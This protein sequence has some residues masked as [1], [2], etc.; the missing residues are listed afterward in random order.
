MKKLLVAAALA[1]L[2][3]CANTRNNAV[4]DAEGANAP[5]TECCG[6]CDK[7]CATEGACTEEAEAMVCPVTGATG[8]GH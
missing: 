6:T 2:A 4:A 3:A 5:A 7:D 8:T 1:S